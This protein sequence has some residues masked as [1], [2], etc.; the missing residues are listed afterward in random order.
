MLCKKDE[1]E[2]AVERN[3]AERKDVLGTRKSIAKERCIV[4]NL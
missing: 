2:V 3:E 4:L 1:V